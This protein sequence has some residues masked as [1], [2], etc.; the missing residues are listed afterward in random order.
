MERDIVSIDEE[1]CSGC[2]I[3]VSAC[4]EGAIQMVNGK[5]RLIRDDYCDGLGACLPVCPADAIKI[6]R[7]EA[8]PFDESAL[9]E[10]TAENKREDVCAAETEKEAA[11]KICA[12]GLKVGQNKRKSGLKN[13]PVQIKLASAGAEYFKN[14]DILVAADCTAY[15][16]PEFHESILGSR[17]TLIGC[18]KLDNV[19][20]SEKLCAIFTANDVKS[21]TVARMEVP[22]CGGLEH[23]VKAAVRQSGKNIPVN[24]IFVSTDGKIMR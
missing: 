8:A 2:G 24:V 19:D 16:C 15:A 1:K 11:V 6:I 20:Y 14:A 22:C 5:A 9:N 3:C 10:E 23:A 17:V 18:P 7:R 13:W 4:H 21:V 12:S